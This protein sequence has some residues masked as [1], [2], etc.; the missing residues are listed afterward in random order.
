MTEPVVRVAGLSKRFARDRRATQRGGVRDLVH[1]IWHRGSEVGLGPSEFWSL[2]DVSFTIDR[3]E[4]VGVVGANGAGKTTL[5]R[6]LHG[7][8]KPDRG[9]VELRG[10]TGA[11]LQLGT[12]FDMH[13]T[14]RQAIALE[15]PLLGRTEPFDDREIDRILDFAEIGDFIDAPIRTYSTGMRLRL[16]YAIIAE[17]RPDILLLDEDLAVGDFGFQRKCARFLHRYVA[18]GGTLIV[19]SHQLWELRHLCDRCIVLDGGRVVADGPTDESLSFYMEMCEQREQEALA[20]ETAFVEGLDTGTDAD[21]ETT[22]PVLHGG[23]STSPQIVAVAVTS[24]GDGPL[25]PGGPARLEVTVAAA[26]P[27]PECTWAFS[28]SQPGQLAVVI[29]GAS[30]RLGPLPPG[31]HRLSATIEQW[32]L[33]AGV[34]EVRCGLFDAQGEL[35]GHLGLFG[36]TMQIEVSSQ[37]TRRETHERLVRVMAAADFRWQ[38]GGVPLGSRAGGD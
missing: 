32:P 9:E 14:G 16:G 31:R 3:G 1:E 35:F 4:S 25:V 13:L 27:V 34:Y 23:N 5:L 7:L 30:P 6:I 26:T 17:L 38:V 22:S 24:V 33:V 37:S 28:V 21:M 2:D 20:K 15:G 36:P 10:R 8:S 11:V 12:S 18:D 29:D 19:V